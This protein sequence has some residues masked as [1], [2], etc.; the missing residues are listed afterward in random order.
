MPELAEVEFYRRC[1]DAGLRQRIREV[2]L[3][4]RKRV[5]RG[6]DTRQLANRLA[7][8]LLIASYARGK[9]ML[10][11]F[12]G[13]NWLGVHLGMTGKLRLEEGGFKAGRHDHLV[14]QQA[15]RSLVF[16]DMRQ[17][18]R[19]L[20]HHGPEPPQWWA[21][22][23]ADV[24]S[25]KF[26]VAALREFLRRHARLSIKA[27]LLLQRGFPGVGN[28]MADE[29]LWRARLHPRTKGVQIERGQLRE[30]WAQ[31]RFVCRRA[32]ETIAIE[33]IDPPSSWLIHQRWGKG[34]RCPRD[35][36][37][38]RREVIGGRTT[39]WCPKCQGKA[40]VKK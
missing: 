38:L 39:A 29:I 25:G 20:F 31:T 8:S 27:A 24:L 22:I 26:T 19:I 12:S 6:T 13:Q 35:Q 10:F 9:Q 16:S 36:T 1:W 28:W 15:R 23:P 40:K 37:P 33:G 34:G 14:L 7:G 17:F 18:G 11:K 21:R 5:F 3:H 30:L 32:L 4:S 2:K